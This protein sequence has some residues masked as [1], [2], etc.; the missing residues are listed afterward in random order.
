MIMAKRLFSNLP[1][2][3][4]L[5]NYTPPLV[6]RIYDIHNNLIS[7][8][9]TERRTMI[10]LQDIPLNLQ[11][12]VM[13]TE[14]QHFY[15][16]WGVNIKGIV[17]AMLTNLRHGRVVEG[18]STITQQLSKVIF[19]GQQ[20][21]FSRKIRELMLAVQL[22]HTYSKD[23]ILQ[24]YLNQI[25]FGHGAYGVASAAKIYF[26]KDPQQMTLAECAT[27][28]G[29]PRSPRFYSPFLNP[30]RAHGRRAWVLSRMRRSGF[31]TPEQEREANAEPLTTEK[32]ATQP[33]VGAYFVE[34]LR[35]L[36]E[37]KYGDSG[38]YQGGYS[39]YTTLDVDMQRAAET[40]M[41][42]YL[43]D[44]DKD[45]A[46]EFAAKRAAE[47][48]HRKRGAP[49]VVVST[50]VPKV[51][52][53]LVAIDPHTG[54]IRAMVG[55]RDF[56]ESQLNRAV[57]TQRQPGSSFKAFVWTAALDDA[58]TEASIVDDDRVAFF[59]DGRDW[60]LLESATDS[61][62]IAVATAPFPADQV[63]VPQNYDLKYFGPITLRTA[64]AM[65]RNLV[66][67][68][69]TDH[70]SPAKVVEY[71]KLCGIESPLHAVLSIGLGTEAV[72]LLELTG[73][74]ATFDNGGIHPEPYA[75][76]RIEDKNGKVVEE[77]SPQSHVALSAQTAYLMTDSLHAVVTS[78]TGTQALELGRPAA[79]KTGTNQAARDLWFVGYTPDLVTG[80]WM[81]YDNFETLGK[82]TA[83]SKVLPWW[84]AFM[85]KALAGTPARSFPVPNDIVFAKID[86]QTGYLALPSCPKV[87]LAAFRKGTEPKDV[88]PID[89]YATPLKEEETEE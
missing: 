88:C 21:T 43:S 86:K 14:D 1:P 79:G 66:S 20:R 50:T 35:Q 48:K 31:I 15:E 84:T 40:V 16:H 71:A 62:A 58:M 54:G 85:K 12:A 23:E 49:E 36:L 8:L 68:R 61:Y 29:L 52:G 51:Q 30:E 70:F 24:M 25:Y 60:K 7:E 56:R 3:E 64:L 63:W 5:E 27:L 78:G 28:A 17:R 11:R 32:G 13:A 22:E 47:A 69:L 34:Y 55:G 9:Y 41:A 26:G 57:Q 10:P 77:F 87:V 67:I 81:G 83:S 74:Y 53:A 76:T 38:L 6:T 18:G 65:S 46:K 72:N 59:N 44:F 2:I 80:A 75:I 73:A 37:P 45:K 39:I 4:S 33:P 42:Q 89:H 82:T 19:F